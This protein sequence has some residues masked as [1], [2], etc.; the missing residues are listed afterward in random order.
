[1]PVVVLLVGIY[2][3]IGKFFQ[4]DRTYVLLFKY[5][6]HIMSYMRERG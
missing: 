4:I 6:C 5:D 1:M 2:K 3:A